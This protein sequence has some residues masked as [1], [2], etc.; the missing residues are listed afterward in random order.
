MVIIFASAI[1]AVAAAQAPLRLIGWNIESGGSDMATIRNEIASFDDIDL[2]GLSEVPGEAAA[3]L[4]ETG[5]EEGEAADFRSL[6]GSSGNDD[7]LAILYD[8]DRFELVADFELSEL[9]LSSGLRSGLVAQLRDTDSGTEFL[10]VVNHLARSNEASRHRQADLL[11]GW[12]RQQNLPVIAVGDYNFD[13]EVI[14]GER[15][16]D[17]GFDLLLAEGIFRWVRPEVLVRS[18]CSANLAAVTED[19]CTFDSVLDFVFVSGAAQSW[20]SR[21]EIVVRPFDFPDS[22]RTSDHRPVYA[23]FSG[24]A[25]SPSERDGVLAGVLARIDALEAELRELRRLV[26]ELLE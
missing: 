26:L 5:A 16:H 19:D 6:V 18:Q 13:Y 25:A 24:F 7:R 8:A 22:D 3:R 1:A 17:R 11:R 14:G 4:L 21:S 10:F 12:A 23:E 20:Q 2:W 15:D 9:R